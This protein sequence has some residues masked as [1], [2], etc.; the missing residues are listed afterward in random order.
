MKTALRML[1]HPR[2][3]WSYL[4]AAWEIQKAIAAAYRAKGSCPYGK[5]LDR[6]YRARGAQI[7]AR[8]VWSRA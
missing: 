6:A 7:K 4:Q 5:H 8:K 3:V 1:R 2:A